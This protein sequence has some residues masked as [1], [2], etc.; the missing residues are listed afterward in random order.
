[1]ANSKFPKIN[2][3]KFSKLTNLR[4][5]IPRKINSAKIKSAKIDSAKINPFKVVTMAQNNVEFSRETISTQ[6]MKLIEKLVLT[7]CFFRMFI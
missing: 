4:K 3:A 7:A 6:V 2:A 1:M 5:L